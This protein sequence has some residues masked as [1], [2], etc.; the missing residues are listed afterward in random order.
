MK[1]VKINMLIFRYMF[2]F[3][4]ATPFFI[5]I[6]VAQ[7]KLVIS[8]S[9]LGKKCNIFIQHDFNLTL[10]LEGSFLLIQSGTKSNL[11]FDLNI[12]IYQGKKDL[13]GSLRLGCLPLGNFVKSQKFFG[14]ASFRH[15]LA[16]ITT[17][18]FSQKKAAQTSGEE[19]KG[20]E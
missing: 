3:S 11:F 2:F 12:V 4:E 10:V 13:A 17:G 19:K 14:A 9:K 8:V 15:V 18:R 16:E 1:M 7:G 20:E 6:S 5:S